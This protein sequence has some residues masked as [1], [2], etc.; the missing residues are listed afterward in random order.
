MTKDFS[1][2]LPRMHKEPGERRDFLPN[3]VARLHKLGANLLLEYGYG[4]E[5]GYKPS[6]Y[7]ST[8]PTIK[9]ASRTEIY[10]QDYVLVLRAPSND[11]IRSMHPGACLISMLHY[12]TRPQRV[13]LLRSLDL[14]AISLDSLCDDSGRR[15]VENLRAVAWN[16]MEAAFKTLRAIYPPPGFDDP[17]RSPIQVTLLGAGAVGTHVLQAGIR[18]GDEKLRARLAQAGVP[19][20]QVTT[21]DYD[22]TGIEPLMTSLLKHTDILVDATQRPDPTQVVIPNRWIAHLPNHAVILDLSVDPYDCATEI[23]SLKGIEGIPQGNLDKYVFVPDD[24]SFSEI[25]S[26]ADSTHRRHVVS[27][28]SWPGIHP[29]QCMEVYG[30]Q[31]QPV[32]RVLIEKGG[33]KNIKPNGTFFERAIAQAQLSRWLTGRSY[34]A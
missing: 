19:G 10:Q 12:P 8:A 23:L 14:E 33:L 18:Y 13:E 22:F 29:R 17:H 25:P 2:G 4:A 7:F 28:Y 6:D 27:C 15:L 24:P 20:V 3:F 16:G 11:E 32:I 5:M 1:I 9:F 34:S 26:C 30:K 21:V 31:I